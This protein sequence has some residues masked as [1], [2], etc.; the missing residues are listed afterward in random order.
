MS[1]SL[2]NVRLYWDGKTGLAKID[3]VVVLLQAA[4]PWPRCRAWPASTT[5]PKPASSR[6]ASTHRPGAT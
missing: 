1:A 5:R 4:R 6:C 2:Y 3:G